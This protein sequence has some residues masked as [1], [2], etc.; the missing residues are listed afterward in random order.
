MFCILR[1]YA[2]QRSIRDFIGLRGTSV[3]IYPMA[4]VFGATIVAPANAL[5]AAV[6]ARFPSPIPDTLS[7][8]F[9]D[10]SPV[11][12]AL[13]GAVLVVLGPILEEI[14]FRGALLRPLKRKV[15]PISAAV[16]T[17]LLFALVHLEWQ[18]LPPFILLGIALGLLRNWSG[19]TVPG[20]LVHATFN[21]A[22]L[23]ELIRS[24]RGAEES[25]HPTLGSARLGNGRARDADRH[26]GR[27]TELERRR[28]S[29]RGRRVTTIA[30]SLPGGGLAG[31]LYQVGAL[32]ALEDG[33]VG[34][35]EAGFGLYLGQAGGS[36][37]ASCLAGGIP[38]ERIYR[39]LLDPADN[40]F[41]LERRHVLQIDTDEWQRTIRT[42]Y[43]AFRHGIL[44]LDPRRGG[45]TDP[46]FPDLVLEQLDRLGDSLPAGLFSLSRFE[47]FLSDFYLRRDVPNVFFAMKRKLFIVAHDLDSGDRV[48][49][50]SEGFENI[51]VS[52]ACAAS[53]AL[54]LFFSPVRIGARHYIDG[55]LCELAHLDVARKAGARL[56]V[57][58]NPRVP[59]HTE[60]EDIPT[61]HGP[62]KSVRDK[63]LVW[64][65]NQ[66]KRIGSQAML[67]HEV[68]HPPEGMGVLV[69]EPRASDSVLFL[70][71]AN[72]FEA[73]RAILEYA[74]RTTRQRVSDWLDRHNDLV[75]ELGW[76]AR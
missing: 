2:P 45:A 55:G 54:P 12:R 33:I 76:R 32:A 60:G 23:I 59:V 40:F 37:V 36:V 20:M 41:P 4:L 52:L 47:R 5:Y 3:A 61:G 74:Y 62:Q 22:A 6:N 42:A 25:E 27:F 8:V 29:A 65:M 56:T 11:R 18:V 7:E 1:V 72:S 16:F 10:A 73:R 50:G 24:A 68:R 53:C 9:H 28:S 69:L 63:G 57:V 67:D 51:P 38:V 15:G 31:A 75:A 39:A 17:G 66:A 21:G 19:S 44:R 13:I 48:L 43:M 70:H 49:F 64:V 14:L 30:L 58:V 34:L 26:P 46:S 35:R 71:N